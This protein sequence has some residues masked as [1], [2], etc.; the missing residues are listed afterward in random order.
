MATTQIK[1][2]WHGGSDNQLLVNPDGSINVNGGGSGGNASVGP[3]GSPVPTDGTLVA[4]KDPS[5]NLVPVAVDASGHVIISGADS[6]AFDTLSPGYPTQVTVGTTSV[7]LIPANPIRKYAHIS[8]NSGESIYIQFQS[9]A[10]LNQGVKIGPGGF[11]TL[12]VNNLYRGDINAIGLI[13]GQ[14]ID[15]VEGI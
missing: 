4:G 10:A 15:V 11:Y 7:L 6:G 13:A 8:N 3:T 14:K 12:E 5:G 1:D 9:S 2:G